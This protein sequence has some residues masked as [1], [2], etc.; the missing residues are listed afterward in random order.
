MSYNRT[1]GT[2]RELPPL[3]SAEDQAL[4]AKQVRER[5]REIRHLMRKGIYIF[6][7]T[8]LV[9]PEMRRRKIRL[10]RWIAQKKAAL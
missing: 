8:E 2:P 10:R 9:T 1:P 7:S 5:E 6:P 3:F 4:F